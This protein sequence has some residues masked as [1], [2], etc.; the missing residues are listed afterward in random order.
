M[1]HRIKKKLA[2]KIVKGTGIPW[3]TVYPFM[4]FKGDLHD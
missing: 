4:N 2:K 3:Q 1:K